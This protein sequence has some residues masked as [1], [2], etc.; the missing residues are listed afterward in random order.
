MKLNNRLLII[1]VTLV[2][3]SLSTGFSFGIYFYQEYSKPREIVKY[4]EVEK[5]VNKPVV[6]TIEKPFPIIVEVPFE[7]P[8]EV[9]VE[10]IV[11]KEIEV[12]I[13]LHDFTSVK[14]L[15]NWLH[16]S[17]EPV[18]TLYNANYDCEDVA[19]KMINQAL[20]DGFY[21]WMQIVEG[22]YYSPISRELLC[23]GGEAH[24]LC[25]VII[26]KAYYFI[27]PTLKEY[28]VAYNVD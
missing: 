25:G 21:M 7:I 5:I 8:V 20:N 3:L 15:E 10:K 17:P 9:E 4:I 26:D 28:W 24:A 22:P 14:E 6:R 18:L 23:K 1:I 2:V 11:E 12:T 27:E 16:S 13:K 19:R